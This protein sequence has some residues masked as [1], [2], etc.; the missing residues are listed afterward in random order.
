M[1]WMVIVFQCKMY[2][3]EKAKPR[4]EFVGFL[5]LERNGYAFTFAY[6][7]VF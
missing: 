5:K 4:V 2:Y 6:K 7:A 1:E 3:A